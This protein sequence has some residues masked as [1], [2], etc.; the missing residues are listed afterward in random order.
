MEQTDPAEPID[1]TEPA[2]PRDRTEPADANDRTEPADA[3]DQADA[4]DSS[5]RWLNALRADPL[6]RCEG[7]LARYVVRPRAAGLVAEGE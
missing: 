3:T 1:R 6:D 2:E 7:M 5:E 4:N